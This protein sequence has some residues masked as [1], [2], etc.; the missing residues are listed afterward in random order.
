MSVQQ[1][2]REGAVRVAICQGRQDRLTA[3]QLAMLL[4][5]I[6][7][8]QLAQ[9]TSESVITRVTENCVFLMRNLRASQRADQYQITSHAWKFELTTDND[10]C[11]QS[12]GRLPLRQMTGFVESLMELV[13]LDW[14]VPD[15]STLCR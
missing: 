5:G 8:L 11:A 15:F 13:G 7:Q 4:E 1:A 2:P 3:A 14:A 12:G 10:D 9:E 6:E